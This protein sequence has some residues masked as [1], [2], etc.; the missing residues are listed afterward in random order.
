MRQLWVDAVEAADGNV[1]GPPLYLTLAGAQGLD[2]Q[3]LIDLGIIG[4]AENGRAIAPTEV[5]KVVALERNNEA[6][7]S[8]KDRL[9]GVRV[10]NQDL[11]EILASRQRVTL[12]NGSHQL[13]CRAHVVNMDLNETLRCEDDVD[14]SQP[15][16][17]TVEL[18]WKLAVLH[19]KRPSLDW[20]L[21]LTLA[22]QIDWRLEHCESVQ[23]FLRENFQREE[24]F[25]EES[26][27]LMG[28]W[29]FDA[30]MGDEI[31]DLT[32][33]SVQEMQALLMVFVPKKIVAETYRL[34]WSISTTYNLRYGGHNG[35]QRM[36]SL[37]MRFVREPRVSKQPQAVYS[38]SL[39]AALERAGVIDSAGTL[40]MS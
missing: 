3:R 18:I 19:L 37:M 22:A 38:E 30:L 26:R 9:P 10:L 40:H 15:V 35:S 16:F 33:L 34:G 29:L 14:V 28:N 20:V 31:V 12:P 7:A 4:L 5:W 6:Y 13:W 23:L 8:L 24:R 27:A 25:A 1:D 36:V 21:C 2:V 17:P 11:A 39:I 32:V